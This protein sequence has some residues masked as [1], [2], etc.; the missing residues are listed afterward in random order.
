LEGGRRVGGLEK[1]GRNIATL[2]CKKK[3]K[4]EGKIHSHQTCAA[5]TSKINYSSFIFF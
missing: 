3:K 1:G 5:K 4:K 2:F